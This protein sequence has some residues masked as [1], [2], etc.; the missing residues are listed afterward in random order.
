MKGTYINLSAL[1][2]A[3]KVSEDA[4]I[5]K[6]GIDERTTRSYALKRLK[7]GIDEGSQDCGEYEV[8]CWAFGHFK[9]TI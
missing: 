2:R 6:F 7:K 4:L 3:I 9:F 1:A 8:L 5:E